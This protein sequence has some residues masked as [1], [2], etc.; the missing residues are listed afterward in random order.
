M[1]FFIYPSLRCV[2][3]VNTKQILNLNEYITLRVEKIMNQLLENLAFAR[4][5]AEIQSPS[6]NYGQ[7]V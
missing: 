4:K 5:T 1:I 7:A 2:I 6:N 3:L